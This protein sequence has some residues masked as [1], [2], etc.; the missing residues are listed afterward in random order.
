MVKLNKLTLEYLESSAY[1]INS[2]S[3]KSLNFD[4]YWELEA[5]TNDNWH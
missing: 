5:K 2:I 4:I 3:S 1:F